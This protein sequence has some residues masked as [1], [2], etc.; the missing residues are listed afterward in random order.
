[1][2]LNLRAASPEAQEV[3]NYLLRASYFFSS[4][5]NTAL[6]HEEL[7]HGLRPYHSQ[8]LQNMVSPTHPGRKK[9]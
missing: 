1:V 6:Q 9:V 2:G 7:T 5:R 3:V 8:K 4:T